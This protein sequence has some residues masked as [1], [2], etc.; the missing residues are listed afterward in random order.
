MSNIIVINS[1]NAGWFH[2]HERMWGNEQETQPIFCV[3]DLRLG[4]I[5]HSWVA[6]AYK[7]KTC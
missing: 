1:S 4:T 3:T 6:N 5:S 7:Q 2:L